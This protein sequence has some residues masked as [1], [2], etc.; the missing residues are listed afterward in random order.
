MPNKSN[1][2]TYLLVA[3]FLR[4]PASPSQ[5][6]FCCGPPQ[7]TLGSIRPPSPSRG[8][9]TH[10]S[11]AV[12][13]LLAC[14]LARRALSGTAR[15]VRALK[16]VVTK[17]APTS[18][19]R[20]SLCLSAARSSASA[21]PVPCPRSRS[22]TPRY[23]I[24]PPSQNRSSLKSARSAATLPCGCYYL[25]IGGRGKRGTKLEINFPFCSIRRGYLNLGS[26]L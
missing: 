23:F 26:G 9:K 25:A 21:R 14:L 13:R 3:P 6:C 11:G 18:K 16:G 8:A 10:R 17:T 12:R 1:P 20:S 2:G 24:T 15:F 7:P 5:S 22:R 4:M 19:L